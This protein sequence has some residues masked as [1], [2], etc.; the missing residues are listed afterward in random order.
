MDTTFQFQNR[1]VKVSLVLFRGYLK[2]LF[3][4]NVL[5]IGTDTPNT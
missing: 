3:K 2:G 1:K 4:G 5:V